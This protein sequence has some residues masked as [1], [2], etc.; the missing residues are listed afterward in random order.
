MG[1]AG[2]GSNPY[3]SHV[4]ERDDKSSDK[5]L[6]PDFTAA[7]MQASPVNGDLS[8]IRVKLEQSWLG[9]QAFIAEH[10]T[11]KDVDLD[12]SEEVVVGLD[13]F[14]YVGCNDLRDVALN[15][16]HM[17]FKTAVDILSCQGYTEDAVV[18]AVVDSA[19]CYQFDGPIT[20]IAEHARTL[21]QSGNHLVDRSYSENVDTVLHML[22]LYFL[23]NASSLMKKYCPFFTLGDALWC[24]LLCDMD[25]SIARA[26]FAPMSGYGNGQS[27][28]Y[29]HSQSDLCEGRE[30][31]NEL[32]E[33][34]S[35]SA[36]E[37][38]ALFEPPQSEAI[39]M[40]WS[41]FLTNYIVSF[42]KFGGKNQDAPSAQD[43]NS[44]SVPR[45]VN[46]KE[47]K[48]KRSKT[49]SI[50]SQKDSGKD[51]VVFKNIP[52]VKGIISKTS[53]RM[54]KEN[55]TLTAFLASAHSTLAGTSE[56]ASEKDSQTSMLVPTK[57]RS[58]PCSV[59]RGYSPAV[60]S[61]GSLSYPPSCSSNS[62]SSAM[63]K[64]EPR[65]RMEPD[66]VHFSLPNTPAEGFEF[67]FSREGLQTTWVPKHRKEE[68]ALK[69]VQ[70]LGE[71][72]LEVQVWTDWANERVMQSTNRLVNERTILFSLKKDKAD[73]EGPDV[74][75][76]KRLEETQRAIDSTSCELDRVN[77][78]VQ[79][80]TDKISLCRREKKSVQLQGEQSDA[81]LA[82]ILSKKTEA[83]NRLKSMETEKILLQEE[84]AAERSKLSKL[85]QSLEQAR[86]HEDVL[87]KK[88]QEGEKMIDALMKQV[89]FERTELE[90]IETSG[91]A[92]S[93]HLLLKARNDQEWLQTSIKNLTQQIAEM[94]SRNKPLS[95]TNFMGRPG[96][97][98]DSVQREQ[99]CAMCLE[100][101]VSVVFL[102]CGHQVVCAGCNQ[103]HRDGGMTECPSCRSPIKRRIC[104]RF[105]DS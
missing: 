88:C 65:Q 60:V 16:L 43:E 36:T 76:R 50:K 62:S 3:C 80:L 66:V 26:A 30:S 59:K 90:R 35:C 105:P 9:V 13:G 42:Q 52:Q 23:C 68:L 18:N 89:N 71:L 82:S 92:K 102:P 53:L 5:K 96:F 24:I 8:L 77:S 45:A 63:G 87:T 57:P 84:I 94:S 93:S 67:H 75:T 86:R 49:N 100:E 19:L 72:K 97:V 44:P 32:S 22:G 34:Y 15:S 20:K 46:K 10:V 58:G 73:F 28:G 6:G 39:Q 11:P 61:I 56:V 55:K 7:E 54:L 70:R 98:I 99:E 74:F 83:M 69:L 64:A 38:P 33:E 104:A 4:G 41:N 25:I 12:W 101:E 103:R 37:S 29:A 2:N 21:L 79:E 51:L 47:T 78:L 17:F 48:S 81:S 40:T 85:L 1:A 95:I 91:R 14:R 31:V 27:E